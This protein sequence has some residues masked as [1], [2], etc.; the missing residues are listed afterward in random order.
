MICNP[1]QSNYESCILMQRCKTP[2]ADFV[3][4]LRITKKNEVDVCFSNYGCNNLSSTVTKLILS[5]V[6]FF[7]RHIS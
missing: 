5:L 4:L 3:T 7:L 6:T 2:D 1:L